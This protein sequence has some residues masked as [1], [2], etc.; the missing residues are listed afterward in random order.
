MS[1]DSEDSEIYYIAEEETVEN[2]LPRLSM[3]QT[4]NDQT[5]LYADDPL[6]SEE[7]TVIYQKEV[8]P[9]KDLERT[10]RNSLERNIVVDEW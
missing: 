6:A 5:D 2:V 7:W 1:F 8:D 4:W 10:L 3:S 9:D